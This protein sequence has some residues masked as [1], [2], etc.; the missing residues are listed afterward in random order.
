M[1][2]NG[3]RAG[4]YL[5]SFHSFIVPHTENAAALPQ[6]H[7]LQLH[8]AQKKSIVFLTRFQHSYMTI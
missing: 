2:H 7:V 1:A 4:Q 8:V 6:D 5:I 3:I